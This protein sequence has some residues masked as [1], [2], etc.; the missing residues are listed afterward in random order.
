M[1]AVM[2]C[3]ALQQVAKVPCGKALLWEQ[4]RCYTNQAEFVT[5]SGGSMNEDTPAAFDEKPV[6]SS[7]EAG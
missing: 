6:K 3:V 2:F 4:T 5:M 7:E 1:M